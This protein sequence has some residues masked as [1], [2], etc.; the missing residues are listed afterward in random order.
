MG[1]IE[2]YNVESISEEIIALTR[3]RNANHDDIDGIMDVA[4]SVGNSNKISGMGFLVDDYTK[5][6][7]HFRRLFLQLIMELDH[8]YVIENTEI[9]GFLIAYTKEQW[10]YYT[11]EWL[12][13][14]IWDP[15]FHIKKLD[16]FVLIDKTAI[17]SGMTGKGLGS[18]LYKTLISDV[19]K[20]DVHN[21][22]AET[23]I[24]PKPN[25]ASLEFRI[26]QDYKLAGVRFEHYKGVRYTDL[27]YNKQI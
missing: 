20:N 8:F 7:N 24:S 22:F 13:S 9:I 16:D 12:D 6:Y 2:N 18:M 3:V 14:V 23:L 15:E 26:K 17:L 5:D 21:L 19:R 4:C 10:L 25:F 11:K 27:V 1:I